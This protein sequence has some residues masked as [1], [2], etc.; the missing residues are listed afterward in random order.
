MTVFKD[1]IGKR[2]NGV[3]LANDN[4]TIVFRTV[5]GKYFRYDTANDCCNTVW[6]NHI[7]GLDILGQG[8]TFD[9]MRGALVTGGEDKEW[10][11]NR[12]WTKA[13]GGDYGDVIQD[14]FYTLKTDRGYIDIEVRND[15]NGYYGGSFME[16]E[17]LDWTFDDLEE[18]KQVTEDF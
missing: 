15:H 13:D 10:T 14:G 11:A 3:F 5:E 9:L 12:E 18:P 17:D 2:I 8:D 7:T 4:W 6:I 16:N 1:L